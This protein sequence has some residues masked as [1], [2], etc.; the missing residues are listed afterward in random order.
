ME[1]AMDA[2]QQPTPVTLDGQRRRDPQSFTRGDVLA[3]KLAISGGIVLSLAATAAF[4]A[5]V[6]LP[7]L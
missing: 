5:L 1:P 3:I 4:V 7:G 2:Q 6:V